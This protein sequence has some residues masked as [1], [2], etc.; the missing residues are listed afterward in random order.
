LELPIVVV[1]VKRG[2]KFAVPPPVIVPAGGVVG[3]LEPEGKAAM[4]AEAGKPPSV[5]ASLAFNA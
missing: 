2:T 5:S 3:L 1:P 4:K